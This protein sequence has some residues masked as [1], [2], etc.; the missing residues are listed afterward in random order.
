MKIKLIST[1][2]DDGYHDY[3]KN[4]V[5][6]CFKHIKDIDVVIYKD[7]VDLENKENVFSRLYR[8]QSRFHNEM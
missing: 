8:N 2:S 6:S 7:T 1:F 4:F 5:E 3:A